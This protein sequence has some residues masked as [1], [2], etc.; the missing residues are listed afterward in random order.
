MMQAS[1]CRYF[2]PN[3]LLTPLMPPSRSL[4]RLNTPEALK[5][6][7]KPSATSEYITPVNSPLI[8]TLTKNSGASVADHF[9]QTRA[10]LNRR[11][12]GLSSPH[13]AGRQEHCTLRNT[14]SGC[15]IMMVKR[16]SRVVSPVIPRGEP[17]GLAG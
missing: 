7:I 6:R 3:M 4:S 5:M 1:A 14:R 12:H 10:F 11:S 16:P 13:P 17:L 15:G 9:S 8:S 2:N